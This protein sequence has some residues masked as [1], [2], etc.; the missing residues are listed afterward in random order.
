MQTTK[1]TCPYCG[2]GCGVL[3]HQD[4]NSTITVKPD[5]EHPANLGRLCSK[6][7]AL[8]GTLDDPDRLLYPE[9]N[10][11]HADWDTANSSIATRF[12]QIIKEH[13]PDAVA[14]YV[15]GQLL[16]EDYYVANKLM[17]GFIG[18]ANIDTNSRLCM[19]SAVAAH[20]RAFGEDLVPCSY[21][22]LEMAELIVLVGSNTAWCH[23][24]LYQRIVKAKKNNPALKV[25]LIDP[26]R[27]QTADVADLHLALKPG[28]DAFLFNGLL[29]YL[30]NNGYTSAGYVAKYTKGM[31]AALAT[32]RADTNSVDQV[33]EQ[34]GLSVETVVQ[35]FQL[36]ASTEQVVSVF[37]QGINQSSSGVDKGNALINCHLLTGRIGLEG[38][39]PF[40]FTGQPNAMGGREVGGLANQLAA[41]M[42]I[43]NPRHRDLVQEFW[44]SPVIAQQQGLKAVDLFEA[45]HAGDVKAVWIMATNP[46]VSLPDTTRVRAALEKCEF[47]VVSDCVSD[48]DT[49]R[50]ADVRLPALTWGERDGTVTNSD[51]TISRQRAFLPVPGEAKADWQILTDVAHKMG[52]G[53]SFPY[54]TSLDVFREHAALSAYRNDGERCFNI[55]VLADMSH[56]EFDAFEPVQWPLKQDPLEPGKYTPTT[57]LFEDSHFYTPDG[58]ANFVPVKPRLPE[59]TATADFPLTLNTGRVRDHWHT[60]TR[61]GLSGRL[62]A[63]RAE[64]YAEIH[65]DDAQR[66]CIKDGALMRVF[67]TQSEICVRAQVST[68][69]QRGSVFVP[70]HWSDT[71]SS[72]ASVGTLIPPAADPIS[73]QPES[74]H[75]VVQISPYPAIWHGFIL[76]KRK[77]DVGKAANYWSACRVNDLWQYTLA[78]ENNAASWGRFTRDLLCEETDDVNWVEYLDYARQ[79]YR[80][81]RFAG[82]QLDSCVFIGMVG[83]PLPAKTWLLTLFEKPELDAKERQSLLTGKPTVPTKDCGKT[84]CACFN[85]GEK[86]IRQAINDRQLKTVEAIGQCLQAGT[87]CGSCLPELKELLG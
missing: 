31:D 20:K 76:S 27:T 38:M 82:Q 35:F 41:H 65:P 2:V 40:S 15:S 51:R 79:N 29:T 33:A 24:V 43:D 21:E 39:G 70:M 69:Q 83:K 12:Q 8:A 50:Y 25:V 81:A 64:A 85:V 62:S 63:H 75:A 4:T 23:P 19:S 47:V 9:I 74:K 16:T 77:I 1:T 73:G 54:Q 72:Q 60:L 42:D 30:D 59:S 5:K 34:C 80:A 78:C 18:S 17:K 11:Q 36:F 10:G 86:T 56:E 49:L 61:T 13:G 14:F 3:V 37:S 87:N 57:R 44:Q 58:R 67:N 66:R 46:A 52:F 32:A 84:V 55:G 68:D 28:T 48:T 26:R 71:F 6:G 7:T 53:Q 45:I 22:D